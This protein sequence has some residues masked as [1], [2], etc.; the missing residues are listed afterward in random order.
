M[1]LWDWPWYSQQVTVMGKVQ[2]IVSRSEKVACYYWATQHIWSCVQYIVMGNTHHAN[3]SWMQCHFK[4]S[5]ELTKSLAHIFSWY[6]SDGKITGNAQGVNH[7]NML[8][9]Y[10]F[11]IAVISLGD[12]ELNQIFKKWYLLYDVAQPWSCEWSFNSLIYKFTSMP[13]LLKPYRM[14]VHQKTRC[15]MRVREIFSTNRW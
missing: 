14:P 1:L 13:D 6:S 9:N 11:Q 15:Q 7:C 4:W 5:I 8:Q 12:N 3:I 2:N 10:I